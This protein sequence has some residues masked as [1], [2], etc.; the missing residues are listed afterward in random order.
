[1]ADP[2]HPLVVAQPAPSRTLRPRVASTTLHRRTRDLHLYLGLFLSPFVLVYA[3]SAIVLNHAWLPWGGRDGGVTERRTVRVTVPAGGDGL[4]VAKDIQRQ[5]DVRGEVGW[6]SRKPELQRLSF[7]IETPGRVTEVRVDLASRL[8]T[9]EQR[10]TGVWDAAVELHKL[11]GPH[12]VKLRGN[13]VFMRLWGWLADAT[14][15]LLLFLTVSGV[16]LWTVLRAER[17]IGLVLL[18]AG[19]ASFVALLL[20]ITV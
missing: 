17:R 12:N 1:M 9:V 10:R 15:Y 13:W 5:V 7:P 4:A 19:A 14:V 11:P 16:Y 8:A 20:A 3:A 18:G 6:V 2:E